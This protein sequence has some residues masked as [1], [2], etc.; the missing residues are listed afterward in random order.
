MYSCKSPAIF[1]R[2][3]F[4]SGECASVLNDQSPSEATDVS[5]RCVCVCQAI[6]EPEWCWPVVLGE[7]WVSV[8]CPSAG[9]ASGGCETSH[10]DAYAW[11]SAA[12]AAAPEPEEAASLCSAGWA[13]CTQDGPGDEAGQ[14]ERRRRA[15]SPVCSA[16]SPVQTAAAVPCSPLRKKPATPRCS[17]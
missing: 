8:A 4:C 2:T 14:R 3:L 7:P 11:A 10:V 17:T 13:V 12:A 15:P 5:L 16:L 9:R 6:W 1:V